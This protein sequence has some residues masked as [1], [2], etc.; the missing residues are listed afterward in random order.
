M[1][2]LDPTSMNPVHEGHCHRWR[3]GSGKCVCLDDALCR[4]LLEDVRGGLLEDCCSLQMKHLLPTSTNPVHDGHCHF[5]IQMLMCSVNL[6]DENEQTAENV[7]KLF[8]CCCSLG[9]WHTT[10]WYTCM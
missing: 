3:L 10:F 5:V 7:W 6:R 4:G 9:W 8:D 1:R 2:H